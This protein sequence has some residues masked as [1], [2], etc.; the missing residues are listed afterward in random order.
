[1]TSAQPLT[2]QLQPYLQ[3]GLSLWLEGGML[4]FKAP[5]EL[6]TPALMG[7][8]K[9][10]KE[11]IIAW[12]ESET[13][14]TK[15][16][17][18]VD[19]FPLAFTQGA[20][21][22]LYRFAPNSPAYNTT[23][24][25]TLKG[26]L[27]EAAVRQAF[28]ALMIRHPMLRTTFRDSDEGPRQQVWDHLEMPLQIVDGSGWDNAALDQWLAQE[29]DAPFD[30]TQQSCLRVK[31][32]RNSVRG[33]VLIATIH[34]V[35]ADL[36]ALLIVAKDIKEFY[37]RAAK[38]EVLSL[39][40]SGTP[41]RHH[42]EWQQAFMHSERGK[43]MRRY[44]QRTLLGAPM[45]VTLPT[46]FP[47]PPVLQLKTQLVRHGIEG[48]T[49]RA[50]RA[51]CKQHSITPFVFIQ[52]ALQLMVHHR[53]RAQDF[54]VGT[55]TMGRSQ[56]GM[57]QVV[58]DFANPVVLRARVQPSMQLGELFSGVKQNLLNAME[59]QDYPFPSVVQD[60]NPPRDS[61]RTP[62]F[63]L[64][65][66]WHQGNA[67]LLAQDDWI[68]EVL[69]LSGPRGAPYDV[70]LA[71]SDL[72]DRFELNWTYQTS[73]YHPQT[74]ET[75]GQEVLALIE[76][77][78][79]LHDAQVADCLKAAFTVA[80]VLPATDLAGANI[81]N[82]QRTQLRDFP[83][84]LLCQTLANGQTCRRLFVEF[85]GR[86]L[87]Q[88]LQTWLEQGL[89]GVDDITVLS[90]LPRN[91]DGSVDVIALEKTPLIDRARM[92][93]DLQ[94]QAI[95]PEK[96]AVL[97]E[98]IMV[99]TVEP[100]EITAWQTRSKQQGTPRKIDISQRPDAWVVG[101]PLTLP[102]DAPQH[103]FTALELT[104]QRCPERGIT[105]HD[106]QRVATHYRYADL[107]TD[108][109]RVATALG[110]AGLQPGSILL[111]QMR[112]D[113]RFFAVWWG[114]LLFGLKPLN[115]A[116]PDQYNERNGVAQKLYNVAHNYDNITVAA[117]HVRLEDTRAWLGQH[118]PVIDADNLLQETERF[119]GAP[120]DDA[121]AFL[122]L[123]SGSTGTPKAIQITHHGI[124]HHIAASALHN[125]YSAD[126]IN[127]NWLPFDHVVPILTT[128]IK[129]CVLGIRQIQLTTRSVL[130]DPLWWLQAM[131]DHRVT[132]S[133]APNFAFQ[134]VVDAIN[135]AQ[136]VP[137]LDLS[138][139]RYLMNAGEQ[140]LAPVVQQFYAA[141]AP[142]GLR[143]HTVQP[144]FG[145]AE[146]C[147]CITYN[148]NS[149]ELLS[150]HFNP[151]VD[152]TVC[153][154]GEPHRTSHSFVDLGPL[155]PGVEIRITDERNQLVK[156]GV[157]GRMQIRGPV[158]TPGYLNN[159]DANAEA[160]VGDGW[161]NSGDLG[162]IWNRR[163]ILTGREK[164]MIVV[165]GANYY[166]FELEQAATVSGVLPTFVAATGVTLQVGANSDA[167]ALFYVAD[168]SVDSVVL[169]R[170]MSARVAEAF[171]L[172]PHFLIP[173]EAEHFHKTTSGKI[174]RGQFKKLFE[175]HIYADQVEAYRERHRQNDDLCTSL[176]ELDFQSIQIAN[177]MQ[178]ADNTLWV[179]P[180]LAHHPLIAQWSE[181]GAAIRVLEQNAQ[182]V[183]TFVT[184]DMPAHATLL[185]GELHNDP[186]T[187]DEQLLA[188]TRQLAALKLQWSQNAS[189]VDQ[190]W[191]LAVLGR[192]Q[193]DVLLLKPL[194]ESLRQETGLTRLRGCVI[195]QNLASPPN[196]S[197]LALHNRNAVWVDDTHCTR[198]CLQS[199][200]LSR[201]SD[202]AIVRNGV[203][204]ITGGLAGLAEP[205]CQY[206]IVQKRCKVILLGRTPLEQQ[207][208]RHF[209]FRQWQQQYGVHNLTYQ[210]LPTFSVGLMEQ[211]VSAGLTHLNAALLDGIIHL[212]GHLNMAPLEAIDTTHW[213]QQLEP[214]WQGARCVTEYMAKHAPRG[215][216][217]HYSSLNAFFGGQGAA[218]YSVANALQSWQT[219]SSTLR[220]WTLHWSV[221]LNTGMASQ[222]SAAEL[223][224][225]RN[226]GLLPLDKARD[227]FWLDQALTQPSGN[228]YIGIDAQSDELRADLNFNSQYRDQYQ[229][230]LH[231]PNS[232]KKPDSSAWLVEPV[233]CIDS[234]RI[235]HRQWSQP[236]PRQADGLLDRAQLRRASQSQDETAVPPSNAVEQTLQ[237]IWSSTLNRSIPDVMRSFFE[238][239]GHSINATQLVARINQHFNQKLTVAHLFQFPTIRAL[240]EVLG[241][242]ATQTAHTL[243]LGLSDF[244]QRAD[245][246]R[247]DCV[248]PDVV[249]KRDIVFLPTASGLA[250]AYLQMMAQL[251]QVR[252]HVLSMPLTH[253]PEHSLQYAADQFI[254]LMVQSGLDFK[255]TLL[256]GW[257]MGGVLGYEL[258]QQLQTK[259]EPMPQLLMLDSGFGAGLHPI[260]FDPAFQLL[261]FAVELG[262]GAEQF[263]EFNQLPSDTDKLH[264]LKQYLLTIGIEVTQ[265][266]L[267]EWSEA[268]KI[269]LQQ[270]EQYSAGNQTLDSH[271]TLLKAEWHSHGRPDLGWG[272]TNKNIKWQSVAADHQGIVKHPDVA[273]WLRQQ[274][275]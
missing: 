246:Y 27:N 165:N 188:L 180:D 73:L 274:C 240:A 19:E 82:E 270:L 223:K 249:A 187:L 222:F 134:R 245:G 31:I 121:V 140:V 209:R 268:Y 87:P 258:L 215:C 37:Q 205:L 90:N 119:D 16:A 102:A 89:A 147:T 99:P 212:A 190:D 200:N 116:T 204:A 48:D 66:V 59:H 4:R 125:D 242:Q 239:G 21:W 76:P 259:G 61:S 25:C 219:A 166:C 93:Q 5:K 24:A 142:L 226:K 104:A 127:L 1:M 196:G 164:E 44:W 150:V 132:H 15:T 34:H 184:A 241:G 273:N 115:V 33:N 46:D 203:Y 94:A 69:S 96:V 157:I 86:M 174:Q 51:F 2:V 221:W 41:Y 47:R 255:R 78:L 38:G 217:I 194:I 238:Y 152:P 50:V 30:L 49:Y 117:D 13:A 195:S 74:V 167:L 124:L 148:N 42:V 105:L 109:R 145:M 230:H 6:M 244:I 100:A 233:P 54:L 176:F 252:L 228:Y 53:T 56:K 143:A 106:D 216:I 123:T 171:G 275:V 84:H 126:D 101:E 55:P 107:V 10:N 183:P 17:Q 220:I 64:M 77:M 120:G 232:N 218:A 211:A 202:H 261:M 85:T 264:W 12:L 135:S 146:A 168:G 156:E 149:S 247:M 22:M 95:T 29:A 177:A 213:Q 68:G 224:L 57:D 75:F 225:A 175:K 266:K 243:A 52:A 62:L 98:R 113:Q 179:V 263:A 253:Q 154:I 185:L 260:T 189:S 159:P 151:G 265:A 172:A 178:Q 88:S 112:Y 158:V 118:K 110:K 251:N 254:S 250:S 139:V 227:L 269:R 103:L 20:I 9:Q 214:K 71:V 35:G 191:T 122:Q 97:H 237:D 39:D 137:T 32:V 18:V 83:H 60:C 63:Q 3:Q 141:C 28:H 248:N 36:W 111:L 201:Q 186:F 169:E 136:A 131:S 160:F 267:L 43:A 40:G 8:L 256:V 235:E 92:S 229:I 108:A 207:P 114:A 193:N 133:W 153:D 208:Q 45:T 198:S 231:Q 163:L 206:L 65:F 129:D 67:D 199:V 257:S 70:M 58:G 262:L 138:C 80:D 271:I 7:L 79:T 155:I 14:T 181:Q 192:E 81:S 11:A 72:G 162:F 161:F 128:H 23:F 91:A 173:V 197:A 26:E 272:E 236:L 234:V 210:V 130:T 144:A 182:G 170:Q